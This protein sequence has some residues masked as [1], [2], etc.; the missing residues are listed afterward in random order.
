MMRTAV[1]LLLFGGP[2][3]GLPITFLGLKENVI[4]GLLIPAGTGLSA[5]EN[6]V[7]GSKE[8]YQRLLESKREMQLAMQQSLEDS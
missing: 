2:Q 3:W 5:F 1:S 6:Q 4:I 7:V 8:E